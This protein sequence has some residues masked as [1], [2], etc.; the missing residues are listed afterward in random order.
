MC[1]RYSIT[2]SHKEIIERFRIAHALME[3]EKRFN[4]APSQMVPIIVAETD[5]QGETRFSLQPAKWG[6]VPSWCKDLKKMR[7]MINARS[8]TA[9]EKPTFR[10]AFKRRRCL[11]PADGFYEWKQL[12]SG[13]VPVRIRLKDEPLFAFAGLYEDWKGPDGETT[14]TCTILTTGANEIISGVHDRMPVI[15]HPELE[16]EWLD[17]SIDDKDR[18]VSM[19]APYDDSKI[20]IYQVSKLVNSP[21]N[22]KPECIEP[23]DDSG[24]VFQSV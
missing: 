15:L 17:S 18:L 20:E 21:K 16:P 24:L 8:E 22:E 6:F 13:K 12:D 1:G 10:A 3:A 14:R 5:D 23:V 11:L 4:I 2:H 9:A 7:P 19:M